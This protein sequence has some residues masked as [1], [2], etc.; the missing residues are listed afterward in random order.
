MRFRFFRF[1][2]RPFPEMMDVFAAKL[3]M[4]LHYRH[5]GAILPKTGLITYRWFTNADRRPETLDE[6]LK[7]LKGSPELR[8]QTTSLKEQFDYR[9]AVESNACTAA[10]FI[11]FASAF[12]I[13]GL[14]TDDPGTREWA[15]GVRK[16]R[17]F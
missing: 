10:Y 2:T 16:L 5:T 13:F 3:L 4:A 12:W 14:T 7:V 15:D 17:P 6:V 9:F 11:Q 1:G 8:R